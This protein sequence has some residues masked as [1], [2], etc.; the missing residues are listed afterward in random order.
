MATSNRSRLFTPSLSRR[1]LLG[2][3]AGTGLATSSLSP[4]RSYA[5]GSEVDVDLSAWSPKYIDS[6]AG[7]L[8]VDTAAECAKVVPLNHSGRLTYWYA[9]PTQ[10]STQIDHKIYGEF[11]AAFAKTYPNIKVEAQNLGYNDMLNKARTAALGNAAP[12]V[13]RF[14]IMWGVEFAAKGQLHQLAPEDVGHKTS[15]F[16][17]GAMKSVTWKDKTYGVPTNNETVGLIWNAAI[18]KEAGLDPDVPPDTWDDLVAY[19]DQI[20]EKTGKFGY[21]LVARVNGGDTP[22][23]FMPQVWGYGGGAFDEAEPHPVYKKILINNA[24]SKAALQ[25]SYDMYVRDHS[26]PVSALTSVQ[27]D[28]DDPFVSGQLGMMGAHPNEYVLMLDRAARATGSD[29][30]MAD[31]VVANMR[32]G[33][34]PRGP[35]RRSVVFGGSNVH[36]FDSSVVDGKLDLDAARAFVAFS[37]GPEWSTKLAWDTSDPGNLRGFRTVWAKQRLE[38]IRF[39]REATAGLQFGIPFPAV[40]QSSEI[41]NII[42]PTMMQNALTGKMS[43]SAAADNAAKQIKDTM[44]GS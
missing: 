44:E 34:M 5:A 36:I 37:T 19:S 32:Y 42:V 35:V 29:R 31:S 30:K 18:F 24:A 17:P 26:A 4:R 43:V 20:K 10:A 2:Y 21:G 25:V 12:M 38:Q 28:N 40:P 16:W 15:E 33:L 11:W 1:R 8:D 13:A 9:G 6:I 3:A 22:F 39:L 41:M 14:P 27:S 7:T 23:R